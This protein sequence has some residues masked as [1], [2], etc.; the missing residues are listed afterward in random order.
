M[1]LQY[2][3]FAEVDDLH[4]G[5]CTMHRATDGTTRWWQLWMRV[6]DAHG[7]EDTF[8]VPMAPRGVYGEIDSRKTWGLA[9]VGGGTW[10]VSPSINVL[11]TRDV[12][13]GEH[14]T[15]G[16]L[17]HETPRIVGVPEGESWTKE[18]P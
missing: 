11:D 10:Q 12:H 13:P 15:L 7:A 17:W 6:V 18:A 8:V 9:S 4:V 14:P 3:S 16:S 5:E 2:R 1:D